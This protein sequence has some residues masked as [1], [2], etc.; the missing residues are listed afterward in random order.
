MLGD[1]SIHPVKSTGPKPK[2]SSVRAL[3]DELVSHTKKGFNPLELFRK[4]GPEE[5]TVDQ[6]SDRRFSLFQEGLELV[7]NIATIRSGPEES[8]GE[9]LRNQFL[10]FVQEKT[11][12]T[13]QQ[14][15]SYLVDDA[16]AGIQAKTSVEA[17]RATGG[18]RYLIAIVDDAVQ[19][20]QT[21][22]SKTANMALKATE[23][24][25][26]EP[27]QPQTRKIVHR[28]MLVAL[29]KDGKIESY[30]EYYSR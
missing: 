29:E 21:I 7:R 3:T 2:T 8:T 12:Q 15:S 18:T 30:A 10:E 5:K 11:Q 28:K 14:V 1:P 25:V 16:L 17:K 9:A 6:R 27:D 24:I 13:V 26:I 4:S 19:Q 23:S 20:A 22:V